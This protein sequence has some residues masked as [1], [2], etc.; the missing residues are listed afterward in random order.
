MWVHLSTCFSHDAIYGVTAWPMFATT[1]ELWRQF[2]GCF[3][4]TLSLSYLLSYS[5]LTRV[6]S[7]VSQATTHSLYFISLVV[8]NGEHFLQ[9]L[10]H[11]VLSR[12]SSYYRCRKCPPQLNYLGH[13]FWYVS[14]KRKNYVLTSSPQNTVSTLPDDDT[15]GEL[16]SVHYLVRFFQMNPTYK[17]STRS[18]CWA[19]ALNDNITFWICVLSLLPDAHTLF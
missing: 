14:P 16:R 3:F 18:C 2:H 9:S 1:G 4:K 11:D 19:S 17:S 5:L 6:C 13:P 10:F 7:A 8:H 12:R 15:H